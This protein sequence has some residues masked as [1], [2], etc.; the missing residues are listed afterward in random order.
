MPAIP[1][2]HQ[3]KTYSTQGGQPGNCEQIYP[4]LSGV[5]CAGGLTRCR[6]LKRRMLDTK[7]VML[8]FYVQNI[9]QEVQSSLDESIDQLPTTHAHAS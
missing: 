9:V 3:I 5:R 1:T 2:F 7:R 4:T 8:F 6:V